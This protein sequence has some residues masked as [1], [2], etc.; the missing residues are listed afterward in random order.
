MKTK[1]LFYTAE[2]E[3]NIDYNDHTL[4]GKK[5]IYVYK[6]KNNKPLLLCEIE[7]TLEKSSVDD[8]YWW[9]DNNGYEHK[10]FSLERL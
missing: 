4:T 1:K 2:L 10:D 7:S 9:L 5:L 3:S 6:I 8:I